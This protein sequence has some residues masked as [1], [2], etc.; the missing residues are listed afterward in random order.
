MQWIGQLFPAI[1]APPA[2]PEPPPKKP[3]WQGEALELS[4]SLIQPLELKTGG[5]EIEQ[6]TESRDPIWNRIT[7]RSDS[8][9]LYANKQWLQFTAAAPSQ[10]LVGWCNEKERGIA[11]RA[12]QLGRVR[13]SVPQ[14]WESHHPGERPYAVSHLDQ[15]YR[16]YEVKVTKPQA[17]RA[18]LTMIAPHQTETEILVTIDTNRHVMLDFG[19]RQNGK[20]TSL[21]KYADYAKVAGVWWPGKIEAFD[22]KS[23]LTSVTTQSVKPLNDAAFGKRYGEERPGKPYRLLSLPHAHRARSRES[24]RR[25]LGGF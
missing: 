21:T 19:Y 18:V 12:Y 14:D 3:K 25:R 8:V 9:E 7:N 1:P 15:T 10:T 22:E 2:K 16:E 11:S 24:R 5:L 13:E 20:I 6:K 17:G 23:R 4:R